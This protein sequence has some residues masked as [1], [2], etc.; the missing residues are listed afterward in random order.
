MSL[1]ETGID[2]EAQAYWRLVAPQSE[3]QVIDGL[4]KC[5]KDALSTIRRLA[6]SNHTAALPKVQQ[7]VLRMG[8]KDE[9]LWMTLA[10]IRELA[11]IIVHLNLDKMLQF[12]EKDTHYRNQFETASSGGLLKPAVREKWERD[13]FSG[14]Y[15]GAQ[16]KDR[17]KYGV[18]NVMNDYRG[19]VKCSQYGD[20]YMIL[21]DVRL[22]CTF[23]P[24]DSANLKAE[25]LAVLDY[26]AHVLNE[27][28][29][30]ELKETLNVANSKDAAKLGDSDAVGKMKYKEAQIHGQVAFTEHV[31]RLVAN[32][33]HKAGGLESRLK[34]VCKKFGWQFS[35][36]DEEKARMQAEDKKKMAGTTWEERL[37]KLDS[38]GATMEIP[39]GYCKVGCGRKVHPGETRSGK[40]FTTC[41]KGCIMGFGHDANCG[42]IDASKVGPGLCKMGCGR[43]VAE[44]RDTKGRKLDTCSKECALGI[45]HKATCGTRKDEIP[46]GGCSKGCGRKVA[47]GTMKNGRPFVTCCRDCALGKGHAEDCDPTPFTGQWTTSCAR[48][49]GGSQGVVCPPAA[50]TREPTREPSKLS[51]SEAKS[52]TPVETRGVELEGKDEK[53]EGAATQNGCCNVS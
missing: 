22:R 15:D 48:Q 32:N 36:M 6:K 1:R 25:R 3:F 14:K 44:G 47:P 39:K 35:W 29:D 27:Y 21:K 11:P 50:P 24:E 30:A 51:K 49:S 8:Y 19:V 34:A 23:S 4:I 40:K 20:S 46:A 13:L 45:A 53:T 41:C 5:Q 9:D 18:Q 7:R 12:M 31:E 26:Y 17:C 33:R 2:D 10:W 52:D 43:P 37:A 16:G 38:L 42:Q 28:S